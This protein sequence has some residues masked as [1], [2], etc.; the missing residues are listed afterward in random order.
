MQVAYTSDL[1]KWQ[2]TSGLV[3][4]AQAGV[5][6]KWHIYNWL[7]QVAIVRQVTVAIDRQVTKASVACKWL[8]QVTYATGIHQPVAFGIDKWQETRG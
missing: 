7:R 6:C 3:Q 8:G 5:V 4:V 2:V 1:C